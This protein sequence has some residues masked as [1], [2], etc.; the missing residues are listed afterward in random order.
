M[1]IGKKALTKFPNVVYLI[2]ALLLIAVLLGL[3]FM[4]KRG[5]G[6]Q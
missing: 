4:I 3:I 6:T 5:F 1:K 2:L